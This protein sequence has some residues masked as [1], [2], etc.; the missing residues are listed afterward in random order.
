VNSLPLL[1]F[2][3]YRKTNKQ[4]P[5]VSILI[6]WTIFIFI[7]LIGLYTFLIF[8]NKRSRSTI[9]RFIGQA[10]GLSPTVIQ[11]IPLRYS[12]NNGPRTQLS[13]NN[14]CDLY[15]FDNCLAIVRTQNFVFKVFFAPVLI[16]GD[17]ATTPK[18]FCYLDSY[19]PSRILFKQIVKGEIDIKLTDPK[20]KHYIIDITFKGLT[21]EQTKQLETIKNWA[22]T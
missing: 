1:V 6:L 12:I 17:M 10:S 20:Y 18:I 11:N 4:M 16:T 14:R 13:P 9:D 3:L 5:L 19:M 15:L 7:F 22:N 8:Y 21:N 2:L